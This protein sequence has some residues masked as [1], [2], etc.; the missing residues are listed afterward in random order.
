MAN[1]LE[2]QVEKRHK[3]PA[4]IPVAK[5]FSSPD[6]SVNLEFNPLDAVV[7]TVYINNPKLAL[8]RRLGSIDRIE[9][10]S[11]GVEGNTTRLDHDVADGI[12]AH[13]DLD[14]NLIRGAVRKDGQNPTLSA[15][16]WARHLNRALKK[17]LVE[18]GCRNLLQASKQERA[19]AVLAFT[20]P[21]VGGATV[22]AFAPSLMSE[23]YLMIGMVTTGVSLAVH[24]GLEVRENLQRFRQA[25]R[26]KEAFQ[27][28]LSLF[29]GPQLDRVMLLRI[30]APLI[31]PIDAL[32][33]KR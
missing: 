10:G 8:L 3:L 30:V 15:P 16:A 14:V 1:T 31:N 17:G 12:T 9:I 29:Y 21:A 24:L 11:C 2:A 33:E 23:H 7:D 19:W 28:R 18:A 5:Y 4:F 6:L 22:A 26:Q 13:I 25:V 20:Q 27:P 32:V